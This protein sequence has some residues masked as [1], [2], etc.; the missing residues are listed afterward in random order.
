[1]KLLYVEWVEIKEDLQDMKQL[2]A[3]VKFTINLLGLVLRE[4]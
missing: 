2:D 4:K 1:M 3:I